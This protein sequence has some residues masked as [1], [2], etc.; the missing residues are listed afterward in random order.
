[1]K[2]RL[3]EQDLAIAARSL[4]CS[5]AIIKAFA[6]VESKAEGFQPNGDP[7]ILFEPHIFSR[8]TGRRFD[9]THP[10]LSYPSWRRD[11]YG[12]IASQ[13]GKLKRA[14][15]LDREAALQSCSWGRFQVMGFNWKV[16]G[17][18]SLQAFINDMYASE[19][20]H[21]RAFVGYLR[22]RGL[23]DALRRVDIDALSLGYNGSGYKANG[24]DV[25]LRRAYLKWRERHP[26]FSNVVSGVTS[27]EQKR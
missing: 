15:A 4:G 20:G 19:Q 10:D 26:D 2:P 3:T 1:M 12:S 21:L 9:R 22:G 17:Y 11:G 25:K 18:P 16:C 5:I 7:T 27:T 23:V 24:Y 8:L 6:E 13:H 14:V